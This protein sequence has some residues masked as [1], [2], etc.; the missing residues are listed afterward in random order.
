M[1][2][3]RREFIK[4]VGFGT[5]AVTMGISSCKAESTEKKSSLG[6]STIIST[7][8]NQGA[9][10]E[11][12]KKLQESGSI[13]D[14]I[15]AGIH[16]PENDPNDTSVGYGGRPDRM[17][18]VTLDACIMDSLG[19][20]G[21]VCFMK[22][23]KNPISI[24]RQV[25]EKTPHVILSGA[26]AERF[27]SDN[28]FERINLLTENS[29][30]AWKEWLLESNYSPQINAERHDTI[31]MIGLDSKGNLAGGCSTSGLAFK[32]EGRVGDSPII[33]AGLFVDNEVGAATATGLGELVL[34]TLG[35]FL[36][37]EFMRNGLSPQEACKKAVKR[38]S[39][40]YDTSSSQVGFIA[41]SKSGDYGAYAIQKGFQY[42]VNTSPQT[43]LFDAKS[44]ND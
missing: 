9:N 28:G 24:A 27:A 25:M 22:G 38:I 1:S 42:V 3:N 41:L 12:W 44:I 40:K 20:A 6:K 5:T 23:Y 13:L 31:G 11:A 8:N 14:A 10:Q 26:G 30:K 18:N 16:V 33:G 43:E 4:K 2:S 21:S 35:T 19:N 7:W 17:G 34:K 36:V 32:M 39:T 37:V 15:E 29:E